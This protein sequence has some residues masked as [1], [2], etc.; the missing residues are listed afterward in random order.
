MRERIRKILAWLPMGDSLIK[1]LSDYRLRKRSVEERFTHFYRHNYW[2]SAESVSGS[3]SEWAQTETLVAALPELFRELNIRSILDIP[4]GDFHWMQRVPLEGIS[5]IGADIVKPLIDENRTRHARSN[6]R[7]EHLNII[8]DPLPRADLVIVRD[9]MIHFSNED[10]VRTLRNIKS[11]GSTWLLTTTYTNRKQ[12]NDI[13]T[14]RWRGLNLCIPPFNFPPPAR[15]IVEQCTEENRA[16][17]D[18]S[19]GLW[20]IA[21]L[22]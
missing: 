21:E 19:L 6:I 2:G 9:C 18:K 12:N 1:I 16:F 15:L 11:S 14:G 17:Q 20:E 4:C 3:G 7:F 5:Y 13:L 8:T 22:S 10:I